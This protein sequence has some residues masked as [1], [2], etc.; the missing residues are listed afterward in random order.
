MLV[1]R[2]FGLRL[3]RTTGHEG[4]ANP[5][6]GMLMWCGPLASLLAVVLL[7]DDSNLLAAVAILFGVLYLAVYRGVLHARPPKPKERGA[8]LRTSVGQERVR[9]QVSGKPRPRTAGTRTP[10]SFGNRR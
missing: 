5:V 10:V 1:Y 9:S 2:R 8:P 7:P 4:L 6:A 3:A